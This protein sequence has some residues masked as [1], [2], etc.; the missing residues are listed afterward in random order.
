MAE[1]SASDRAGAAD[2]EYDL[3]HEAGDHAVP[4]QRRAAAPE[5]PPA[6]VAT[7]TSDT[8]GDYGYDLAHDIPKS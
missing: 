8:S 4:S 6:V 7:E 1:R 2:L 5:H 3:A